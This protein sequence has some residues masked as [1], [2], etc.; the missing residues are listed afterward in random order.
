MAKS[1]KLFGDIVANDSERWFESDVTPAL[2]VGWLAK[3]EGDVEVDINSNGGDCA[4]G[5]AI[6]N[7]IKGY[8]KGKVTCNVL[9]VAASMA[10]VIACAGKRTCMGQ[11]AFLMVH[12]PWTVS[13]GN[14]DD[15]RKDA[16]TLDKFRDSIVS[17]Y[18]AKCPGKT[19]DDIK[20]MLD[21]ETW[22]SREAAADYGFDIYDYAGELKAAAALTRRAFG[23]APEAVRAFLD[24]KAEKPAPAAPNPPQSPC[25][26]ADNWEARY[27]G[28]SQKI[29][30]LQATIAANAESVKTLQGQ[31]DQA[32]TA[33]AAAKAECEQLKARVEEGAKALAAKDRELA[34]VRDSLTKAESEVKHLKDT[35]QMLT[36]GVLTQQT[37]SFDKR[38]ESAKSPEEREAI[39]AE[40]QK[41][42]V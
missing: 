8:G 16:E 11:G 25:G 28:A 10:S 41:A 32:N 5:L 13:M 15:L 21:D 38:I 42:K 29:N 40:K 6:A 26:G 7:A 39:R 34:E 9:G 37:E 2:F 3:Q 35:R 12:N 18:Q 4:A 14:A 33:L 19:A 23:N 22:I 30:E 31:L 27:K 36:A 1:F 17:F 20:V 24:F